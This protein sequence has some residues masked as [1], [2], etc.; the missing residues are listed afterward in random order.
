MSFPINNFPNCRCYTAIA[1]R[2][3]YLSA[4]YSSLK[5]H[6]HF[7]LFQQP[8][9]KNQINLEYILKQTSSENLRC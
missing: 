6:F 1:P 2:L 5:L 8:P 4:V 7:I 9:E 3:Y